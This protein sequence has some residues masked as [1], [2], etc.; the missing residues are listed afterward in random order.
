MFWFVTLILSPPVFVS[1]QQRLK[2]PLFRILKIIDGPKLID[3]IQKHFPNSVKLFSVEFKP[4]K[5]RPRNKQ[6][7]EAPVAFETDELRLTKST[8]TPR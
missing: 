5:R 2:E 6:D 3:L 4:T 7:I 1:I 8:L